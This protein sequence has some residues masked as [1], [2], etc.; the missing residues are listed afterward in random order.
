MIVALMLTKTYQNKEA[1]NG[2]PIPQV[3]PRLASAAPCGASWQTLVLVRLS[4]LA[5]DSGVGESGVF[6]CM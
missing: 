1:P 6:Y 3:P 4:P 5:R 2:L